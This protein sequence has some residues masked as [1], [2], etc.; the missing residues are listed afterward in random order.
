MPTSR[1]FAFNTGS[2]IS[3]TN[4]FG[5]IAVG[6]PNA[7]NYSNNYGGVRWFMGPDE[8]EGWVIAQSVPTLDQPNP[9]NAPAGVGFFRTSGFSD[10][11]FIELVN[12]I[13]SG[14]GFFTAATDSYNWLISNG[15]WTSFTASTPFDSFTFT[16]GGISGRTGPSLVQLLNSYD[17]ET[18]PWLED[19]DKFNMLTN[20]IQLW[21]VPSTGTYRITVRGAQGAPTESAAGGRG[22]I[23][24]GDFS[25]TSGEKLQILVGQTAS[26]ASGRLYRSSAGGGGSFVVKYTGNVNVV[27]DVLIIAGGGGGS[28]SSPI[29]SQTDAQT[30][31]TAGRAIL[32]GINGGGTGGINGNGGNLGNASANGAG[33]GF[34]TNGTASSSASGL[35]FLNGGLGGATNSTY[36]PTGGGFGGG[37][38]PNNGDLNRFSGGGGYSGGGAS[39]TGTSSTQSNSGGGGGAS[40]N[41]GTNQ[42]N[43]SGTDG[44]YGSGSV[45]IELL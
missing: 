27:D 33:G 29:P 44:N 32:N 26:V 42:L 11:G 7:G 15:Y 19:T 41:I 38:A 1:P 31:T 12:V 9:D 21:T 34:L 5:Q 18:Y 35:S 14:S 36:A 10:S 17:T 24:R 6:G 28:G 13:A 4:Q 16:S 30:G 39:N 22:A 23:M 25:L 40:Y 20:G 45:T 2:T 37:G 43:L 8:D 3:G